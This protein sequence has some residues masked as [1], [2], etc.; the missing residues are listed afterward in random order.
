MNTKKLL[1]IISLVM[2]LLI[3]IYFILRI[4]LNSPSYD[5]L[6]NYC[7]IVEED[8]SIKR[9]CNVFLN[10]EET[11][12]KD[13]ICFFLVL[14]VSDYKERNLK[15]CEK[16]DVVNWE[17]PYEDYSENIPVVISMYYKKFPL[18]LYKPNRINIEVLEDKVAYDL[19]RSI[20]QSSNELIVFRTKAGEEKIQQGYY[21]GS[22]LCN[23]ENLESLE[24]CTVVGFYNVEI[25]DYFNDENGNRLMDVKIVIRDKI[26]EKR[27]S[28][29]N[30]KY[31]E[32]SYGMAHP[33]KE[34]YFDVDS[35]LGPDIT[36]GTIYQAQFFVEDFN[37]FSGNL[38]EQYI[39]GGAEIS[40]ILDSLIYLEK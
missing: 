3:S 28:A 6:Y 22:R 13:E 39:S 16:S 8:K 32:Y 9:E 26:A 20:N 4:S 15:I 33:N 17:N 21:L 7:E 40:L 12:N 29:S 2:L 1:T 10:N 23:P 14:P 30:F 11:K 18:F 35:N 5:R 24:K 36:K 38:I 34:K 25:V 31:L 19:V 37:E 27:V